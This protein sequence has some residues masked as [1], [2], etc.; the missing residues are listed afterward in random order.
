MK[1]GFTVYLAQ[2]GDEVFWAADSKDLK[3][4]VGTGKT[5][6]EAIAELEENEKAWLESAEEFKIPIP[7]QKPEEPINASGKFTVR[8]STLTH[9]E[10]SKQARRRGVSLNQYVNDA[11]VAYSQERKVME[12]MAPYLAEQIDLSV[13]RSLKKHLSD[14]RGKAV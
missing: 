10:A 1:F 6:E 4:C 9:E 12:D 14:K 7:E 3:N 11:I 2:I 8:V 13:S 5:I